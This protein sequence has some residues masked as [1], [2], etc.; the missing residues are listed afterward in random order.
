MWLAP[1]QVRVLPIS[2]RLIDAAGEVVKKLKAAGIRVKLDDRNEKIGY[3][4]RE[5]QLEKIPYMLIIGDR[6]AESGT[7][8]VRCRKRGD[9]GSVEVEKF[10]QQVL[11][12]I[13]TRKLD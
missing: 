5:A 8:S 3:K 13:N 12:E 11:E 7:V 6:E 9:L 10:I 4:I 2:E 1:E